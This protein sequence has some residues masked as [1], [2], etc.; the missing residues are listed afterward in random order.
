MSDR[1]VPEEEEVV[2][3]SCRGSSTSASRASSTSRRSCHAHEQDCKQR[4][5]LKP[6]RKQTSL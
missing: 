1:N 5:L 2:A 3:A 4:N 6:K